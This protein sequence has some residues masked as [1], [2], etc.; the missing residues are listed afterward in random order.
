MKLFTFLVSCFV[1][2]MGANINKRSHKGIN[3]RQDEWWLKYPHTDPVTPEKLPELLENL[4]KIFMNPTGDLSELDKLVKVPIGYAPPSVLYGGGCTPPVFPGIGGGSNQPEIPELE[5]LQMMSAQMISD[6]NSFQAGGLDAL[7]MSASQQNPLQIMLQNPLQSL[8]Q[9][10][11]QGLLQ[12]PL[13][14]LQQN[15]LQGLFQNQ[16][17]MSQQS[18]LQGLLQNPVQGLQQNSLQQ[19]LQSSVPNAGIFQN[20]LQNPLQD[21]LQILQLQSPLSSGQSTFQISPSVQQTSLQQQLSNILENAQPSFETV[22]IGGPQVF[23]TATTILQPLQS[24]LQSLQP[25]QQ[26]LAFKLQSINTTP[27]KADTTKVQ[28]SANTQ[29]S[30]VIK[31]MQELTKLLQSIK[32]SDVKPASKPQD[33][34]KE[35]APQINKGDCVCSDFCPCS[36][37]NMK[38]SFKRR[39]MQ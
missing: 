21:N 29:T 11:L 37:N 30:E 24:V 9:N 15:Q 28:Q 34:L 4:N 19:L 26:E 38:S 27:L 35:E 1:I 8:Q 6:P 39:D 22:D 10:S 12:N 31:Q 16:P 18:S 33:S 36:P 25:L 14:S 2:A 7:Q 20:S 32:V 23:N 17:Q 13:Q 5:P 3:S